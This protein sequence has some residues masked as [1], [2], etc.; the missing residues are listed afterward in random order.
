[1]MN[2]MIMMTIMTTFMLE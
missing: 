2:N 1:M